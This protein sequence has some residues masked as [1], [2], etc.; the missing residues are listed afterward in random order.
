MSIEHDSHG[1]ARFS[2]SVPETIGLATGGI[3]IMSAASLWMSLP[4]R[5]N[6]A[7]EANRSQDVHIAALTE[8]S[9]S[10]NE[11]V[12]ALV[13]VVE[14]IDKRTQRIENSLTTR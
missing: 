4:H 14:S 10:R 3:A 7:E 2:F 1:Q 11:K 9:N 8:A 13:A 5:V 6:A 12:A